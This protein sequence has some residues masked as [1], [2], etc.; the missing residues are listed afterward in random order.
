MNTINR[1][2]IRT[3]TIHLD[4]LKKNKR[5]AIYSYEK[6]FPRFKGLQKFRIPGGDVQESSVVRMSLSR[7]GHDSDALFTDENPAPKKYT[8]TLSQGEGFM[9]HIFNSQIDVAI[10]GDSELNV[11]DIVYLKIPPATNLKEQ[12]GNEDKY[13]SGKYLVINLRH[14][15]LDGTDQMSTFLECVKD[16]G[17]KQ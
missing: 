16:T 15:L 13:L 10:P 12:D 14:K 1:L 3:K 11:G 8:E 4:V 6:Q 5:E 17:V 9:N 7:K 2:I